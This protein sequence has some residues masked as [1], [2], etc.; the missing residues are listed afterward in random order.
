M[1]DVK[2][3]SV[4]GIAGVPTGANDKEKIQWLVTAYSALEDS[5][6]RLMRDLA[7]ALQTLDSTNVTELD[8][9][10]TKLKNLEVD[11]AYIN[12]IIANYI[13]ANT[14]VSNT[15]ITNT[16]T[17]QKGYIADL[18]VDS[19]D[20][21]DMV[22]R[23][24]LPSTDPLRLAPVG[25]FRGNDQHLD[26]YDAQIPEPLDP[27][28]I[29]VTGRSGALLYWLDADSI[30]TGITETETAYPVM[31]FV[32]NGPDGIGFV[33][34][35]IYHEYDETTGYYLPK[36]VLGAGTGT[37]N[38]AKGFIY[39]GATGL[40]FDYMHSVTGALRRIMLTD[41]GID[42]SEI[43]DGKVIYSD[44]TIVEGVVQCFT[45]T[46]F[47]ADAKAGDWLAE[48]DNPTIDD[49]LTTAETTLTWASPRQINATANITLPN[50]A[51]D[52][53]IMGVAGDHPGV[54]MFCIR[55]ANATN[56]LISIS[57]G[58]FSK[59]LFPQQA[60]TFRT[61]I[62]QAWEVV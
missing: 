29:Q 62:T 4:P 26:W 16:L 46:V 23:Y 41:D 20:T 49:G 12:T 24:L 34:L 55:N 5:Y 36:I 33:K 52:K 3:G 30:G 47:P 53:N 50:P 13:E 25:Y 37:E 17:A 22:K 35:S 51:S 11:T 21:S 31:R 57:Y 10:I 45:D 40:Y 15:I 2:L 9:N 6:V 18:T 56:G 14:I 1:A 19:I 32:Y 59:I 60:A 58:S 7:N 8:A 28:E 39:K 42:F 61:G 43:A 38:N 44:Q 54:V 48:I 27:G